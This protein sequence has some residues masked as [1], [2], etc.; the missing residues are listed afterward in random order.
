MKK[1]SLILGIILY[2]SYLMFG[3]VLKNIPQTVIQPN[4]NILHCFA[5]GDEY[6]NWLHD[7]D[8]YTILQDPVTGYYVYAVL[9]KGELVASGYVPDHDDPKLVGLTRGVNISPNKQV[10]KRISSSIV[11]GRVVGAPRT[12]VLNNIVIFIRF[13]DQSEFA[14]PAALY[15]TMC[16]ATAPNASSMRQ[17]Y[18]EVSYGALS[19]TTHFYPIPIGS[20]VASYQDMQPRSYYMPYN[21]VTNPLGYQDEQRTDREHTLLENAVNSITSQI[22][23]DL[24]V[25]GDSDGYVD[26]VCFIIEGEPTAWSSLLWPHMW[27]LYTKTVYINGKLVMNF[28]LQMQ[29]LLPTR[30][31]GV[32]CHEMFH[33]LGAPDLYHYS[34]DGLE[35]VSQWDIMEQDLNPPQHMG[36]YM[37]WQYGSWIS[38]I[39]EITSSGNYSLRPLKHLTNNCYKI[40]SPFSTSQYFVLEYRKQEG[41]F[42]S[43]LPAEGL[44]VYRINTYRIGNANGPPDEVYIY[45][46]DG[47]RSVNGDPLRAPLSPNIARTAISDWTNP[48]S[49]LADGSPGGL[50][51]SQ[52]ALWGDSISFTVTISSTPTWSGDV[53]IWDPDLTPSSGP[54]VRSLLEN[55]GMSVDY[56]T[57]LS[58]VPDLSIYKAI[59]VFLGISPN[60]YVLTEPE[61]T[62][63]TSYL[64]GD[65]KLYL[66]GGDTWAHDPQTS[67]HS[68]FAITGIN[69]GESDLNQVLGNSSTFTSGLSFAYSG[70]NNS[71]DRLSEN[72][73]AIDIFHNPSMGYKIGIAYDQGSYKT[74]GTSFELGGL[75]SGL[76]P[77]TRMDLMS[78]I[79][80]FFGIPFITPKYPP[81]SLVALDSFDGSVFL[82]WSFPWMTAP[83]AVPKGADDPI[84]LTEGPD[85]RK[86]N[87]AGMKQPSTISKSDFTSNLYLYNI[88]RDSVGDG[89]YI[90]IASNLTGNS[91]IDTG[92][93]N[94]IK[95]YYTLTSTNDSGESCFSPKEIGYPRHLPGAG[96]IR[97]AIWS[98]SPG[99]FPYGIAVIGDTM[100]V[101]EYNDSIIYLIRKST[102]EMI[103]SFNA[104]GKPTGLAWDGSA[105]WM[106]TSRWGW[107][108]F[109]WMAQFYR[110]DLTGKILQT[111]DLPISDVN[112]Y[113]SGIAYENGHVWIVERNNN[114]LC[115]YDAITGDLLKTVPEPETVQN[116]MGLGPRGLAYD[117]IANTLVHVITD[118]NSTPQK[119]YVYEFDLFTETFTERQFQ[120]DRL[121]N[122][123][124]DIFTSNCRG[125]AYDSERNTYWISDVDDG[126]IYEV[127]PFDVTR[128]IVS[129]NENWN[130]VSVPLLVQDYRVASTYP[131][132][133]S[134]AFT[135]Q[136]SYDQID[137]LQKGAG[138]W[139][140]FNSPQ[141]KEYDGTPITCDTIEVN[142]K[143]NIIGS[144]SIPVVVSGI[145]S[146]PGGIITSQF[147]KYSSEYLQSDTIWP[148]QAYWIKVDQKGSLILSSNR[149]MNMAAR[150]KIVPTSEMPPPPPDELVSVVQEIPKEYALEQAYPNPFNPT[151]TIK[152]QLPIDS[153]VLMKVYNTLGQVVSVLK[154]EVQPA[155]FM[156]V[157]WDATTFASGIYFYRL[158][159]TSVSDPSKTF[160]QVKKMILLR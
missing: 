39:P 147:L 150:I 101:A 134:S 69:D 118:F 136:G 124:Q 84:S 41:T 12:G 29:T 8:G 74:I 68:Y 157:T 130:M 140:K 99:P 73:S 138:F 149:M 129:Y 1:L 64:L 18:N 13:S 59:F 66:E 78:K 79:L 35:P 37:K 71:I 133:I 160:S 48:S 25:D 9:I 91:Y 16:N 102:G 112:P 155:G 32:L 83:Q 50:N 58:D 143:W 114:R 106:V 113:V 2:S 30:G 109:G 44:L 46:P 7:K 93:T 67:L 87:V 80:I 5:S 26:N 31:V 21:A 144:I 86:Y 108:W 97:S 107:S 47:T 53:L 54:A 90:N 19:I 36:A 156:S 76:S 115:K 148:G 153:R 11:P 142:D 135:Y 120:F 96:S 125:I 88:Y 89:S 14:D 98:V 75:I 145:S 4:G 70:E 139:V 132:A 77:N 6:Y 103:G 52:V 10:Q 51:V 43:S 121:Y 154:D 104:P 126:I 72:S 151:T 17:Y 42:E 49:F 122:S 85:G 65:G 159:A 40:A 34:M 23:A 20:N 100:C 137:T 61:A 152:Y 117:P 24:N 123:R 81:Q 105:L 15:D 28:N 158:E 38:S 146:I 57:V 119:N 110:I 45:R 63:F 116:M 60:N 56:T 111:F 95:Y 3:A 141:P 82:H 128:L 127:A 33:T 92:L 55:M 131:T 94:G 22:P 27:S 62:R